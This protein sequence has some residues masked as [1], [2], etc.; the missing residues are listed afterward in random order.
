MAAKYEQQENEM[1]EQVNEPIAAY[2]RTASDMSLYIPT[3]YER[4]IIMRSEKDYEEGRLYTQEEVDKQVKQW[5]DSR[6]CGQKLLQLFCG[7]F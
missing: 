1:P 7:G 4:E 5:L 3:E 2:Q 6:L